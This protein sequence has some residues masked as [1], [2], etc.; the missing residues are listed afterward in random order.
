M[1]ERIRGRRVLHIGCLDHVPL[2]KE[3]LDAGTWFH[4][5]LTE[6][7]LCCIGIDIDERGIAYVRDSLGVSNV[8]LLDITG[9]PGRLR[10]EQESWDF[11]VLGE[12]L[13]HVDNP[14]AFLSSFTAVAPK[15][16]TRLIITVPN[17]FRGGNLFSILRSS[18]TIN[19]DHRYWFT[20]YTLWKIVHQSG[21]HVESMELCQFSRTQ[22]FRGHLKKLALR[23][24]P[25]LAE[26]IVVVASRMQCE[27]GSM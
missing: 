22:G 12:V 21:W 27:E 11:A 16:L 9:I 19:S 26:D 24:R 13:E 1:I 6:S 20:P 10:I 17:A 2:I 15:A 18:E 14:V 3:K 25:M 23:F 8:E 7:A 5:I 4:G